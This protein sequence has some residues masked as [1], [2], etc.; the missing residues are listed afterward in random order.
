MRRYFAP[1]AGGLLILLAVFA[2]FGPR[3][4]GEGAVQTMCHDE[5]NRQTPG[6]T[7]IWDGYR[8]TGYQAGQFHVLTVPD[9]GSFYVDCQVSGDTRNAVAHLTLIK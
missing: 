3:Q 7:A 8:S 6:R 5:F 2:Y 9:Q 1:V 4:V